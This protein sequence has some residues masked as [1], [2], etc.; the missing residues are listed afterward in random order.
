MAKPTNTELVTVAWL[1]TVTGIAASGM[2]A[3]TL[4]ADN[5]TWAA[6]GFVRV[7][8]VVGGARDIY[9]PIVDTVVQLDG[10]G[11]NPNSLNPDWATANELLMRIWNACYDGTGLGV[12]LTTRTGYE[13]AIVMAAWPETDP[14]RLYDDPAAYGH[15][16]MDLHLRWK[17]VDP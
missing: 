7:G 4:P 10:F 11:V 9:V 5:S 12:A 1:K 14:R 2:V 3:T 17:R 16:V 13:D 6:S 8:P 15:Y